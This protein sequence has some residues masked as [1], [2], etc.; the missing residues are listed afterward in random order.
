MEHKIEVVVLPT[1]DKS[2]IWINNLISENDL[3]FEEYSRH[4]NTSQ[5]LYITVS[6]DVEPIKEGDWKILV[7]N[8]PNGNLET[9][10]CKHT[11]EG[12]GG[13][14]K[15]IASDDITLT[16][17]SKVQ[18]GNI[19]MI[20]HNKDGSWYSA[21]NVKVEFSLS[22]EELIQRGVIIPQLQQSFLKEFVNN[23]DEEYKVEYEA[24]YNDLQYSKFGEYAPYRLKL[25]QDKEVIITSV[26]D[27]SV[28]WNPYNKVVQ[29]HRDGTIYVPVEEKVY[30]RKEV[31]NLM[32]QAWIYGE[33]D[34]SMD[35][36][37]REK[38]IK[39]NL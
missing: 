34:K 5:H 18:Y 17:P 33:A 15:I 25:N 22:R 36:R 26:G 11:L 14:R 3:H 2:Q 24:D 19:T 9:V 21:I 28:R 37:V 13:G 6:Q 27:D 12:V 35:Y 29:S 4:T 8:R 38:W 7:V 16:H 30:T 10:V 1:E 31:Y 39:E 23:P 20:D 32:F